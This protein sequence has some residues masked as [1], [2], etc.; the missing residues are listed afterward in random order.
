MFEFIG[1]Y[2]WALCIGVTAF[3][4]YVIGPSRASA[5]SHDTV[6]VAELQ[7]VRNWVFG[8]MILPWVVMGIAQVVGGVSNVWSLFRPRD[9]NPFV[10]S[11]YAVVFL[12]SC[13]FAYWVL[14]RGGA[15][16]VLALNL[17]RVSGS[18]GSVDVSEKWVKVFAVLWPPFSI[19]WVILM[20]FMEIPDFPG[21]R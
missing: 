17:V 19:G 1:Q 18:R 9:L 11:W 16:Y 8:A 4:V 2:F 15:K 14:V 6:G 10:W 21:A 20:W 7:T 12:L 3:N 13:A 5:V